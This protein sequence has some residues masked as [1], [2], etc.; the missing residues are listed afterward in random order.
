MHFPASLRSVSPTAMGLISGGD[1]SLFLFRA[2]SLPPTKNADTEEGAFPETKIFTTALREVQIDVCRGTA[3]ASIKC[4]AESP[5]GPADVPLGKE[6]RIGSML[7]AVL[8]DTASEVMFGVTGGGQDWCF[9]C[10]KF[11]FGAVP[12]DNNIW[13]ALP[14]RPERPR[15]TA[16]LITLL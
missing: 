9:A 5:E 3:A 8:S 16:E 2:I 7:N 11:Q 4:W 10:N 14:I 1:P 12:L 6:R 15:D 13:Q